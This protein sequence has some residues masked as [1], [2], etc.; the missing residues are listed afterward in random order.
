MICG[1][2]VML[3][4]AMVLKHLIE[5]ESG[6][7]ADELWDLCSLLLGTANIMVWLGLLRYVSSLTA[8]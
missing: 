6:G 1:N 5:Q 4:L 3:I 2:D 7:E 8:H